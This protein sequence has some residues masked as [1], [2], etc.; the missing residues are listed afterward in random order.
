MLCLTSKRFDSHYVSNKCFL[1]A[2]EVP[3]TVLNGRLMTM[4][5]APTCPQGAY[6]QL[7]NRYV[8]WRVA[9]AN[10]TEVIGQTGKFLQKFEAG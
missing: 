8:Q 1:S 10:K 4:N 9:G 7:V 2:Y 3:G 5:R 6:S